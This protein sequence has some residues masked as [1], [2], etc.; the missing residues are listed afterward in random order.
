ML[1]RCWQD[2]RMACR[3]LWRVKSFSVTAVLTFAVGIAG[4]TAMF[5]VVDG[6]LLVF[7]VTALLL[8]AIGIYALMAASVR[9]RRR[10]IGIPIALGATP[11]VVRQEV[12]G[13]AV[14]VTTAGIVNGVVVAVLATRVL[15]G[16]LFGVD[17][18]DP[19]SLAVAIAVLGVAAALASAIPTWRASRTDPVLALR[20]D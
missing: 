13:E 11:A 18:Q 6:V 8:A 10:E 1:E 3:G 7:G 20:A 9:Q 17:S 2:L 4:T 16:L 5:A 12:L 15:R 19:L 14:R